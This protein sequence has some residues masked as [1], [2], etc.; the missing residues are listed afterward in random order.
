MLYRA[1]ADLV[2]VAHLVFVLFVMLGGFL[3]L[4]RKGWAWVHVP[5]VLWAAL[6][7]F[8]GWACPLTPLE[9]WFR[10]RGGGIGYQSSFI[11]QYLLP[12]LYPTLLTRRL[13][14]TLG[15]IVLGV[16]LG[17][18]AWLLRRPVRNQLRQS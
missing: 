6:I 7:E 8:S 1:L 14:I 13:Q 4:R 9:N 12:L 5:A 17:V 18:Y 2:V 3:V 10:E 15:L 11:E 16:N